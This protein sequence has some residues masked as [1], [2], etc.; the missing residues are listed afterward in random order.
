M[1]LRHGRYN[2]LAPLQLCVR[3]EIQGCLA[4]DVFGE[5]DHTNN[6]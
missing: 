3:F 1:P 6:L 5:Q 4:F 2:R